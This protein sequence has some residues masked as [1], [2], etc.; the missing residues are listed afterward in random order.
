MQSWWR[1]PFGNGAL[2][3]APE[4]VRIVAYGIGG[5]AAAIAFQIGIVRLFGS[6]YGRF[7]QMP[8]RLFIAGSFVTIVVSSLAVGW[9]LNSFCRDASGSGIPELRAAFWKDFGFIPWR[10]GWVKFLA[11][12]LS[13]G[14]GSS[15]GREGPS[16]QLAGAVGSSIA[17]RMGKPKQGRRLGAVAGAAAGLAGAFNTPLAAV[18]FVLE[19]I[20]QDLNSRLLGGILLASVLGAF[21]A[22]ELVGRHPAFLLAPGDASGWTVYALVPVVAAAA[23]VVGVLFQWMTLRLRKSCLRGPLSRI[24][25]VLR[26][27]C[28][29]LITWGLGV[30][31]FLYTGR[32]GVF[33]LGYQ[34]LSDGLTSQ[35]DWRIAGVL[36]AAK[37][38]ATAACYGFGGCGGIFTPT[39]F[40]GAM[41]GLWLVGLLVPEGSLGSARRTGSCWASWG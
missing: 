1:S 19:E 27:L 40:F 31:V 8:P 6:T 18:T 12:V 38:V 9:L 26:P 5:G 39:L 13:I 22:Y 14:G 20:V 41:S 4:L 29:G 34:D 25:P 15:L 17:G 7:S 3:R 11:G 30:A 33:G 35:L 37:L 36:L 16:A 32:L 10:V 21:V 2:R 24:P 28:G 23:T